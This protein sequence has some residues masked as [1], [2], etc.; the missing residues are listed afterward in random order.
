MNKRLMWR[1]LPG[2]AKYAE[3]PYR[4]DS[5]GVFDI[6]SIMHDRAANGVY[7][8]SRRAREES[9]LEAERMLELRNS[10]NAEDVR[11][12]ILGE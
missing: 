7:S 11:R 3:N 10:L 2:V 12:I 9:Q 6:K 8:L 1:R 4:L 5:E